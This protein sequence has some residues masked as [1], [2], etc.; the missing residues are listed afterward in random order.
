MADII[1]IL[2]I[3]SIVIVVIGLILSVI[4]IMVYRDSQEFKQKL[5]SEPNMFI[6][7]DD[8]KVLAGAR[9]IM[10]AKDPE[11]ISEKR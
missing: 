4:G 5:P 2:R 7:V 11:I 8:G 3:A 1:K 6:L 10:H 9:N